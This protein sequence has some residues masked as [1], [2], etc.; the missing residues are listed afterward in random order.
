[1]NDFLATIARNKQ[2]CTGVTL[3]AE[4]APDLQPRIATEA[5]LHQLIVEFHKLFRERLRDDITFLRRVEDPRSVSKFDRDL[6]LL[7]TKVAHSDNTEANA[8]YVSWLQR[9]QPWERAGS[10]LA[11]SLEDA[12][13]KLAQISSRVRRNSRL[14]QQWMDRVAAEPETI[15]EAVCCDMAVTF[16]VG[17]K[18]ALI[19]NVRRRKQ[20]MKSGVNV[21]AAIEEYC[22][23]EITAQMQRLPVP[24]Y[25]VLD[26]LGLL[27]HRNAQP[28]L[29]LAYSIA[30]S[31]SLR[32][33]AFLLRTEEAWKLAS[34]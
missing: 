22:A 4:P 9:N 19:S 13:E 27:G 34:S 20:S 6:Y 33:E 29:L 28:A 17:R 1:M 10:V 23:Q 3:D 26:R 2:I 7:R 5:E 8:F 21:R 18:R 31:T 12:L 15:F 30:G 32:G 16:N 11:A 25:M 14:S 24:Y